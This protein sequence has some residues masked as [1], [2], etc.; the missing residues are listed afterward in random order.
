[1]R[2]PYNVPCKKCGSTNQTLMISNNRKSIFCSNCNNFED[3]YASDELKQQWAKEEKSKE[4]TEI[5]AKI[6]ATVNI[7]RCPICKS[8]DLS[9]ITTT[10]KVMKIAAFGIFGMGDNGKT[11]KCN[12]CGSK[13]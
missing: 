1:M 6:Q 3:I 13:F 5:N 2:Q 12:S 11:W 9:K 10:K 7:P 8:V 4:Q